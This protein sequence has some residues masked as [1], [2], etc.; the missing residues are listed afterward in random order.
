MPKTQSKTKFQS[1]FGKRE[2][3]IL[4]G[5]EGCLNDEGPQL[6]DNV[7]DNFKESENVTVMRDSKFRP[8]GLYVIGFIGQ[9]KLVWLVDTGA[10]RNILSYECYKGL[11]DDLK[12]PLLQDGSQVLVADG[13]RA[14][15]YGIGNLTVRVGRQDANI[16]VLV[17]DIEDCA[18]LGMEFLSA[19]DEKIDLVEQQPVING[20]EIDCCNQNC[21]QV[22]FRRVTRRLVTIQPHSEKVIPSISSIDCRR[23]ELP[24]KVC[25]FWSPVA[26]A[27]RK[28]DARPIKQQPRRASPSKHVEIER[29]VED[30]LQRDII[31]K[32]NS[33]W[34]SPVV[35]VTKKD[36]S[37]RFC[38]DY[39]QVN[40][41]TIKDAYLLPHID[42]S[43]CALSGAKWF[44]TLDLASGYWQVPMDPA[45]SGKAAFVTTS[46]LYEWNVM[47]FSL[48]SSP[49][50]FER[51]MEL[52]LAGL[53]F[54]T[55]LMTP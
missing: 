30:L 17:T 18:I 2:Q 29:Q 9:Y 11:P 37:Q 10:T 50:T 23:P 35:L 6:S 51:L 16:S 43:L 7:A 44:S 28:R 54:E 55:C 25:E 40:A 22:S 21:Q 39:R 33:P 13:R 3:G 48:T 1:T 12:F 8:C 49:S 46:G 4:K 52:I 24:R 53:R 27:F 36:G 20:E 19:V 47:P 41:V 32:S 34:S 15:T 5:P 42:D 26:L 45:S 38:V 31:K 14:N